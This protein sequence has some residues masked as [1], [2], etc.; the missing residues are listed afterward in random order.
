MGW[1]TWWVVIGSVFEKSLPFTHSLEYILGGICFSWIRGSHDLGWIFHV[2]GLCHEKEKNLRCYRN[3]RDA[4][5][6]AFL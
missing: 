5:I 6:Y 2:G 1:I 3:S 4:Y